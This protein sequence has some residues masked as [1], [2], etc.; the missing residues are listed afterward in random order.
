VKR[1]I[2]LEQ[3]HRLI[4]PG[5][6]ALVTSHYKGDMNV[7]TA[8]WLCP[9]SYRPLLLGLA[10]H[11]ETLTHELIKRG[12]EFALNVATRE[13]LRQVRYCGSVSG[14]DQNKLTV[15]GLH[16]EGP[17]VVRPV[18]IQEC[19]AHIECAVVQA[20][21]PGDHTLFVAE[22]VHAQAEEEAFDETY[23]L[24]E[25][26]LRPL[27]HLGGERYSYLETVLGGEPVA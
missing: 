11:Q 23:L 20:I 9:V 4:A 15:T 6:L 1:E 24:K 19:I 18:L 16:E 10:V 3:A 26:D 21:S 8:G 7:M 13:L 22:I 12:G 2:R 5:P 25:S 14:R 17:H 27:H